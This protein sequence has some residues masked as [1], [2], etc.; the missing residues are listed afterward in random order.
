MLSVARKRLNNI[1]FK[2]GRAEQLDFPADFFDLIFSVDVIHHVVGHLEY[3]QNAYRILNQ[4]GRICTA[5]DSEWVLRNRRPLATHFPETVDV[6]I[7]RYPRIP[8][9]IKLMRQAGFKDIKDNLVEFSFNLKDIQA[10]RDKAFSS[11]HLI[12]EEAFSRGIARLEEELEEKGYIR[13]IS[14]YTLL[15]GR[16]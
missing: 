11:L 16:K 5:T 2:L 4:G 12:S 9:L 15:W 3:F 13:C 8:L 14:R 6:E 10:Y 1:N 7:A